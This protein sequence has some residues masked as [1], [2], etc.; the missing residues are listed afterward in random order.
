MLQ[1]RMA[2]S[3]PADP[4]E[5]EAE[6]VAQKVVRMPDAAHAPTPHLSDGS[7]KTTRPE[8]VPLQP[9]VRQPAGAH[10]TEAGAA[11]EQEVG[12]SLGQ[13]SPLPEHVRGF[14][15]PRFGADFSGVRIHT[16][17]AAAQINESL[18]A[19]AFTVQQDIF[20]GAGRGPSDLH[21]TAHELTH[22]L[23][24]AGGRP[25]GDAPR[26]D[27]TIMRQPDN[28]LPAE[29]QQQQEDATPEWV[30]SILG[31]RN[32]TLIT[33][34]RAVA[35]GGGFMGPE[36]K[37]EDEFVKDLEAGQAESPAAPEPG[38]SSDEA[39]KLLTEA[40]IR[41]N[42][43]SKAEALLGADW[44]AAA[45]TDA[46]KKAMSLCNCDP[47]DARTQAMKAGIVWA[48]GQQDS[49]QKIKREAEAKYQ[50]TKSPQ[51]REVAEAATEVL[52]AVEASIGTPLGEL[53][54]SPGNAEFPD[55]AWRYLGSEKTKKHLEKLGFPLTWFTTCVTMVKPVAEAAG[56][57]TKKWGT[58][59]MFDKKKKDRFKEAQESGAWVPAEKK[60]QPKP[61][62]I[63]I[64]VTYQK[65]KGVVQKEIGKAFFQHVAI[66]VKP[67]TPNEDGTERWV[68]ADGGKGS[69][70]AGEDKTGLTERRYNPVTQ[71][72]VTGRQ[73]NLQEAAEG[74]RYLLGFWSII[75]LPR[76]EPAAAG[77]PAKK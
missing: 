66:L 41:S 26:H 62:D 11:V 44:H 54:Y 39:G 6:A 30:L 46:Y 75:R 25:R 58:L 10:G 17:P 12:Q 76:A 31:D 48:L 65:E 42:A 61:G 16:G 7:E 15:E 55:T 49:I 32:T 53:Q 59:D 27:D 22:V 56:V 70:H 19:Q 60:E 47:Q 64:S 13:G 24:Q 67:V 2:L 77:K 72:F 21:L 33:K 51:A 43:V 38:M 52:T 14:M 69:S 29:A 35:I 5:Q 20:F 71:Q 50:K 73:S 40:I 68:T 4:C 34:L 3:R 63:L 1:A 9:A 57:D 8:S 36:S 37:S 74:G 45:G 23:Q 28:P 18:N